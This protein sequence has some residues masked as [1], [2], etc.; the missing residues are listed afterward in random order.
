M[1]LK[2]QKKLNFCFVLKVS[3]Y[4]IKSNKNVT[5]LKQLFLAN[6]CLNSY[7]WRIQKSYN[8]TKISLSL[9]IIIVII[10]LDLD[11]FYSNIKLLV[12]LSSYLMQSKLLLYIYDVLNLIFLFSVNSYLQIKT[13]I[14]LILYFSISITT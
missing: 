2:I 10:I 3:F 13:F 12:K 8:L 14:Q 11:S 9:F 4:S 6:Q 5:K 1:K 7:N